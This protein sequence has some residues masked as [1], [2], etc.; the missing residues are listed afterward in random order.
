MGR[1]LDVP[2][3]T[4]AATNE[5]LTAARAMGLADRDFAVVFEVLARMSGV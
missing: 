1:Q 5:L 3:P 2:L 4:T